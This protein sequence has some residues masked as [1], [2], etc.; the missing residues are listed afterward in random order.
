[1]AFGD[2]DLT[3]FT[4]DFGVSVQ[5][6]GSI[7]NGILDEPQKTLLGDSGF[8]G[9]DTT[10]PAVLLPFNAFTPMPEQ[11]EALVVDG[12]DYTVGSIMAQGDGRFMRIELKAAS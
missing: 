7:A 6:Q 9:V 11:D 8:G 1:M 4:A 2:S 12:T 5:F 10:I 3:V